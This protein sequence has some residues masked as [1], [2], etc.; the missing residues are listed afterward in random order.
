[1]KS[2]KAVSELRYVV[3]SAE[4]TRPH[5]LPLSLVHPNTVG[6][7]VAGRQLIRPIVTK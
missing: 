4:I 5:A 7:T 1:M 3:S 6:P 2:T